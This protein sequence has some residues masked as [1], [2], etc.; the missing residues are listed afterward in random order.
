MR[1]RQGFLRFLRMWPTAILAW[2]TVAA[3]AAQVTISM[4][5]MK[6]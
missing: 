5:E 6:T 4:E 2:E 3:Q 1:L